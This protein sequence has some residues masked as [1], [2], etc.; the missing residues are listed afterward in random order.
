[1][2]LSEMSTAEMAAC[3]CKVAQPLSRIGNDES[4]NAYLRDSAETA[5]KERKT[6]MQVIAESIGVLIPVLMGSRLDDVITIVSAMTGKSEDEVRAQKGME[7][8]S[9]VRD[10]VDHDFIDFFKQSAVT[11]PMK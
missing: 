8:I 6:Q 11:T 5:K 3:L 7:T 1:M 10:F 4:I 2:K 9:D